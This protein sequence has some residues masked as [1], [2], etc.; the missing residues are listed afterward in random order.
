MPLSTNSSSNASWITPSLCSTRKAVSELERRRASASRATPP[1]RSSVSIFPASIR[2]RTSRPG[3]PGRRSR[4]ATRRPL[5][6]GR[7]AACG[8]TAAASG[9]ASSSTPSDETASLIGFAKITRDLTERREAQ[10]RAG[11]VARAAVPGAEDG[12]GGP[13]HRRAGARFQQSADRHHRQPGIA[14]ARLAQGRIDELER[15]ITRGRR[16]PH[17]ARRR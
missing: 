10:T 16:A 2:P 12:S 14:E 11:A 4:R 15:Y 6:G 8:R 5:R 1:P 7:L 17:R 9:P 13:A 3:C